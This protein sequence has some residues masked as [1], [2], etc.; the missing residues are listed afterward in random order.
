MCILFIMYIIVIVYWLYYT[1]ILLEAAAM[2]DCTTDKKSKTS[3]VVEEQAGECNPLQTKPE[4][5]KSRA[6]GDLSDPV[7]VVESNVNVSPSS[8]DIG[9]SPVD[10]AF[11]AFPDLKRVLNA[12]IIGCNSNDIRDLITYIGVFQHSPTRP[13]SRRGHRSNNTHNSRG[14]HFG[15]YVVRHQQ[16]R[17]M[18]NMNHFGS[19]RSYRNWGAGRNRH[20]YNNRA[21]RNRESNN[22]GK[23]WCKDDRICHDEY[24]EEGGSQGCGDLA[25]GHREQYWHTGDVGKPDC[26]YC[27]RNS[28]CSKND[29][30][31]GHSPKGQDG[32]T[33]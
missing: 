2:S 11:S 14:R 23:F 5:P 6:W 7:A 3:E 27:T 19:Y 12:V 8:N 30:R 22:A 21:R 13:Q 1:P 31:Y 15:N 17:R 18:G 29:E 32:S 10:D 26:V 9:N 4:Q 24:D 16:H 20:R 25:P 28:E 33:E